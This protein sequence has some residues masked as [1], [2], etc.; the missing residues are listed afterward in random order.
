MINIFNTLWVEKYR[1][2]ELKDV[3]LDDKSRAILEKILEQKDT[4][5]IFLCGRPGIGK[6]TI[7]KIIAKKISDG[8][9]IYK[10]ASEENGIDTVRYDLK[11]YA[12]TK[13]LYGAQKTCILDEMDG[14]TSAGQ[15]ALRNI[16]EEY[17]K[18]TRFIITA[19]N[20]NNVIPAIQSRC[21]FI[22]IS[23]D[24]KAVFD[25]C[26]Y[27]LEQEHIQ[28]SKKDYVDL[29]YIIK[30]TFPDIRKIINTLQKLCI[31]GK[32]VYD[33]DIVNNNEICDNIYNILLSS[34][35]LALREFLIK[36]ESKI[37][38]DYNKLLINFLNYIYEKKSLDNDEKID[39]IITIRDYLYQSSFI[40]DLEI[41]TISCFFTIYKILNK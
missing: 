28:M 21:I 7:A 10:N 12:E 5:H 38:L 26:R 24:K 31:T 20:K 25:R 23:F 41:N 22:D 4:P 1:P 35:V 15:A 3:V 27:I 32:F 30:N 18:T 29:L 9:S 40:A 36:N 11:N 33:A 17:S 2:Q 19:N 34:D 14:F 39:I 13:S 8:Q 6:T 37:N 16:M